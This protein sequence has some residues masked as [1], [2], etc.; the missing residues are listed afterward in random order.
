M[1]KAR[2][3]QLSTIAKVLVMD[4]SIG[5]IISIFL[6]TFLA[7]YFYKISEQNILYLSIYNIVGW[8]IA[9]MGAVLVSNIIKRKD[10]VKLYRFGIIV[11][12]LYI[13]MIILMGE[14]IINYI[15]VIGIMYGISTATTGFP[16]NM[17]ESENISEKERSKY[18]GYAS[19]A[20]EVIS[21]T[22]PIVIGAY[23]TI[24]SYQV[25]A[26]LILVFSILKLLLSFKIKN[27]NMQ[28]QKV[29]LREFYKVLRQNTTLKKL[30][31]IEFF[32]GI[33]RYG[34]MSLVVSLLIIYQTNNELELGSWTALFSLFTI[35]A[36]Y[37]FGKYY[38]KD[39]KKKLLAISTIAMLISFGCILY[40]I[41]MVSVILYN[42][43]YYVFMNIIL[44]ITEVDLFDYSNQE[45]YKEQFNTEYFIFREIF[46]NTG[47]I[48]GYLVLLVCVGITQEISYLNLLFIFI[49]ISIL[50]VS[51]VSGKLRKKEQSI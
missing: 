3:E 10:K 37:L 39:R 31:I 50:I 47:R 15:Y 51:N 22:I 48:L 41:N 16:F 27:I 6:D 2:K 21:L 43:V 46:L 4:Q 1:L 24:Q 45:P 25:A 44:K 32:K 20:T 8:I 18:I 29:N 40:K 28:E 33:N 13:F 5:K 49:I 19:V 11:K 35:I 26:V 12:S 9:T 36:M 34:V 14:K 7:A 30:Y 38:N 23:I 42:I 17:I